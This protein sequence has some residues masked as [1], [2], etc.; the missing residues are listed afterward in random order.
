MNAEDLDLLD[1]LLA[2]SP[3]TFDRKSDYPGVRWE[4]FNKGWKGE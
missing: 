2:H 4:Y 3:D 1:N